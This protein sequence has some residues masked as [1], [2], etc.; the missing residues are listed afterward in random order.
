MVAIE[1]LQPGPEWDQ[2]S[3]LDLAEVSKASGGA[4][5]ERPSKLLI[6]R[7]RVAAPPWQAA[8][9]ALSGAS[10]PPDYSTALA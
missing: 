5:M 9:R 2:L 6:W 7:G 4:S 8:E 1:I 10:A 3:F